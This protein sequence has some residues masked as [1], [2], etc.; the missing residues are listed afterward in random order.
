MSGPRKIDDDF[1]AG[2]VR[3]YNDHV[4]A[5][6]MPAPAIAAAENTNVRNVHRWV[7]EAR[8]RG[9]LPP[10]TPPGLCGGKTDPKPLGSAG[11]QVAANIRRIR[12]ARRLTYV[13]LSRLLAETGSSVAVLGLRRIERGER[14][15]DVD[16]LVAL[17]DVLGMRPEMLWAPPTECDTCH[18]TPPPGFAC[19]ECGTTTKEQS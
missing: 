10:G 11:Q 4:A 9:L 17:A 1:L 12:E 14:R 6:R 7:Y 8:K 3:Q 15:V 5:K 2:I 16:D 19:T 18:G 13:E